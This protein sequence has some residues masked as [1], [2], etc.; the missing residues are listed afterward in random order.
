[1][2]IFDKFYII[3]CIP[4]FTMGMSIEKSINAIRREYESREVISIT[5]R[6]LPIYYYLYTLADLFDVAFVYI[7]RDFMH[8]N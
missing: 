3:C 4:P 8:T 1:M 2:Q 6:L 7:F 5:A